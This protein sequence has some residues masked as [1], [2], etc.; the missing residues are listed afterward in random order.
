MKLHGAIF[1]MDG[2][3]IN[4]MPFWEH[5]AEYYLE[6]QG[7]T[8]KEGLAD[9]VHPMSLVQAIS[10]LKEAYSLPYTEEIIGKQI[11][12]LLE[13]GYRNRFQPKE[14]VME[15]LE[16]LK[17]KGV[18]MCIATATPRALAEL[19]L[20]RLGITPYMEG[21]LTCPEVGVGKSKPVIYQKA[22]ELLGTTKEDTL[23]FED[24]LHAV[25]TAKQDGF[26][27]VGIQ[28]ETMTKEEAEI[29]QL[30]DVFITTFKNWDFD[31]TFIR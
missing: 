6:S 26:A 4:S 15:F 7:I 29:R 14:G 1:D 16:K 31:E 13:E 2:T 9:I 24:A 28:D 17:N 18:R 5:L 11:H 8:P 21:L 19:A 20:N 25:R 3:L 30:S 10:Y 23:I 27:V 22:L 12:L